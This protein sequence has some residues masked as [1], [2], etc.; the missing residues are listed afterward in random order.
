MM[1]VERNTEGDDQEKTI[2]T[3][4][5]VKDRLTG[6]STGKTALLYGNTKTGRL[7]ERKQEKDITPKQK[8]LEHKKSKK[9]SKEFSADY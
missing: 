4:R 8:R 2:T 6:M 1:A 7:L 9:K 3:V 5:C